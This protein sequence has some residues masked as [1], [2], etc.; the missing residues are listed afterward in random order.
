MTKKELEMIRQLYP[1]GTL[2]ELISMG[3]DVH[4]VPDGTIG[5]VITVDDMG[6]IHTKWRTGSTL[7]LISGVDDFHALDAKVSVRGPGEKKSLYCFELAT[8]ANE[9]HKLAGGKK[10]VFTPLDF[11]ERLKGHHCSC[12]VTEEGYSA[13]EFELFPLDSEEVKE[14]GKAYMKCRICGGVSHL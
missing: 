1:K 14:G 7:G 2:V 13:G 10:A 5:T 6:T 12:G 3:E 9:V 11:P 8:W 4:R